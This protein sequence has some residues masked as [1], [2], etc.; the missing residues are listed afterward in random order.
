MP[1]KL[2]DDQKAA[3]FENWKQTDEF[4]KIN[5][6]SVSARMSIQMIEMATKDIT[7]DWEK[8]L[9]EIYE[10]CTILKVPGRKVKSK[11]SQI[12]ELLLFRL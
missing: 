6:F 10:M 11:H 7:D 4:A 12:D 3:A 2:T 9:T 5:A 1:K 8:F